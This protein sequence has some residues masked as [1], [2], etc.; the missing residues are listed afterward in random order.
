MYGFCT[1]LHGMYGFIRQT[2][3]PIHYPNSFAKDKQFSV[4]RIGV[5]GKEFATDRGRSVFRQKT[6]VFPS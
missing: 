4:L 3:I 5:L 2:I 1:L 6:A